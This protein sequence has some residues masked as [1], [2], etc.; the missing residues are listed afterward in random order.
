MRYCLLFIIVF[1][2]CKTTRFIERE[3]VVVDSSAIIENTALKRTLS[4]ELNRFEKEKEQ[5]ENTGVVFE[6]TPCPDSSATT[7]ITFDNGKVKSIEGRVKA[8][9]QS[10]YKK[11][12]ELH[13]AIIRADSLAIEN[14]KKQT[15][16][17]K[18]QEVVVK[19]TTT[20]VNVFPWWIWFLLAVGWIARGYWPKVKQLLKNKIP[21]M[22]V[23]LFLTAMSLFFLTGCADFADT[24]GKSV[25]SEGLWILPWVTGLGAAACLYK[26]G[27]A[28]A[29]HKNYE[30]KKKLSYGWAY[31]A[32]ALIVATIVIIWKVVGER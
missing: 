27:S 25:W 15:Q 26:F 4:E 6:T 1:T 13:E 32:G 9:N 11:D 21:I 31:F 28:Y 29:A 8:L 12:N 10:L 20:K 18:K 5:W 24:P 30:G 16:L 23:F 19:N 22:K 7:K 17:S 2:S 3:K 14:E